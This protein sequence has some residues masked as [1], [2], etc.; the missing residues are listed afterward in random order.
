M[1]HSIITTPG[2]R[3]CQSFIGGKP[4][5]PE[6]FD[7]PICKICGEP[8]T[9]FFQIEFPK[10]HVWAGKSL[11][12]FFCTSYQKH[13]SGQWLPPEIHPES[14]NNFII[15]D[16]ELDVDRYQTL[17]RAFVFD[18]STG[19]LREDC[20]E[21]VI[22]KEIDWKVSN[23]KTKTIPII[24]GNE[25]IWLV[26]GSSQKRQPAVYQGK[27]MEL[28]LQIAEFVNFDRLPDAPPEISKTFL[29]SSQY[30][31][32]IEPN[33]TLF[34]EFNRIYLWGT[35]DSEC[36]AIYLSVQNNI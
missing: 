28:I 2:K 14:L 17:F 36:P 20:R 35:V 12:F 16:G 4:C 13:P 21:K 7:L 11:A 31:P 34:C 29:Q 30:S 3:R 24:L 15:P 25:P 33:Y 1:W 18:T 9:F 32:R 27:S 6:N 26:R 23:K 19:V 5:I 8:L 10:E 22:Y